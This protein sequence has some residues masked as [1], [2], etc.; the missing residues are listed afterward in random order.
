MVARLRDPERLAE[1]GRHACIVCTNLGIEQTGRTDVHHIKRSA[2]G[3]KLGFGQK[4]GDDRTIPLCNDQ[5]HW[6]GVRVHM[7]SHEFEERYG[8]EL[9]LLDQFNALLS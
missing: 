4:A 6:N 1:V 7:G 5:H 3:S 2:D 8:N 9:E